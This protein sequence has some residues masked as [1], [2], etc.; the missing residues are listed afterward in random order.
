M[1]HYGAKCLKSI[2]SAIHPGMDVLPADIA[3][4]DAVLG[5]QPRKIDVSK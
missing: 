2:V 1:V 3:S 4:G 5:Y